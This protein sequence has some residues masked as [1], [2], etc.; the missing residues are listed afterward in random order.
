MDAYYNTAR[1]AWGIWRKPRLGF[2]PTQAEAQRRADEAEG[3]SSD[4]R[5]AWRRYQIQ[6]NPKKRRKFER[7]Q[8]ER[9]EEEKRQRSEA[10]RAA[11]IAARDII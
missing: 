11:N 2:F 4:Q 1:Q 9:E 5:E 7:E 6:T 3:M 8:A 10:R